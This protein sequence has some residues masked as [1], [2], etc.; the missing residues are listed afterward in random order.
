MASPFTHRKRNNNMQNTKYRRNDKM[1]LDKVP[2][3]RS[4]FDPDYLKLYYGTGLVMDD[5]GGTNQTWYGELDSCRVVL[6][7][8]LGVVWVETWSSYQ[9]IPYEHEGVLMPI[10]ERFC[11]SNREQHVAELDS[12]LAAYI[13]DTVPAGTWYKQRTVID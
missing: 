10:D 9:G 1:W 3:R 8:P 4:Y 12:L 7:E 11:K 13:H 6:H 2:D 5:A